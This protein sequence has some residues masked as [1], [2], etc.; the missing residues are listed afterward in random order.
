MCNRI[1]VILMAVAEGQIMAAAIQEQ[2]DDTPRHNLIWLRFH[3]S[4]APVCAP[5]EVAARITLSAW[6]PFAVACAIPG[7]L[8]DKLPPDIRHSG[9]AATCS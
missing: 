3:G 7:V 2:S 9:T 5:R 8:A 4:L 1:P 6:R